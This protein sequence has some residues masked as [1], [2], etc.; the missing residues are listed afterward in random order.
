[1]RISIDTP[2]Y[3]FTSVA[4]KR[5]P[6]FQTDKLKRI[7]VDALDEARGSAGFLIFAYVIMLD[8]YHILTD[9]QREASD[10]LRFLNGISAKRILDHLK[11]MESPSLDK[12]KMFEKKRGYKYSV[13]EHHPD[14]FLVTSES[15]MMQKVDYIHFNPVKAG[16]VE[17][18]DEYLYSSS[19]IWNRKPL[20]NEPLRVDI[21]KIDWKR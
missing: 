2:V 13:W 20:E 7:M 8:H 15:T 21:E 9:N 17:H 5:L 1:M 6:I 11:A 10:T 4:H 12:L 14:T 16:F 19:R 3:F 18:P